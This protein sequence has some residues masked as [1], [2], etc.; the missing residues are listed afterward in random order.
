MYVIVHHKLPQQLHSSMSSEVQSV[1]VFLL[2]FICFC[3]VLL[4]VGEPKISV[5][6][7]W[8]NDMLSKC[9]MWCLVE[10]IDD[11]LFYACV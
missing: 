10:E 3:F 2:L 1:E 6:I 8:C 9:Y 11:V 5:F 7:V 4:F